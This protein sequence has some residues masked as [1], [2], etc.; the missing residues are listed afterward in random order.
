MS[1][2]DLY[3]KQIR[4]YPVLSREEEYETAVAMK[5]GSRAARDK[6]INSNLRF[7]VRRAHTYSGY[8]SKGISL[9]DIIQQG[10]IGLAKAADK[11]DPEKK[12]KFISYAVWW[13]N[14]MISNYIMSNTSLV[15]FGTTASGR[16]LFYK[17]GAI[18]E[19][20]EINDP[21]ER[22]RARKE[23]ADKFGV[24]V[25]DIITSE[26]RLVN[27][28]VSIDSPMNEDGDN[29]FHQIYGTDGKQHEIAEDNNLKSIINDVLSDD[30]LDS[31]E[32][33]IIK[34]RFMSS[35]KTTLEV[36]SK[37]YKISRE[38]ARQI[39]VKALSKLQARLKSV[40]TEE[41]LGMVG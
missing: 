39:Q 22:E 24:S 33:S 4:Q 2:V 20:M 19:I 5:K 38:R 21:D 17:T 26:A 9:E 11:F 18:R 30:T 25:Q 40:Y 32:L 14:A 23:L 28:D 8:I 10:N 36:I 35:D 1:S 27:P 13:I 29:T 37:Q 3:M 7:V 16:K 6:L 12:I 31:R 34:Q 41:D 15:K